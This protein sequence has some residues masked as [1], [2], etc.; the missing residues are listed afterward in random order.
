MVKFTDS[1]AIKAPVDEVFSLLADFKRYPKFIKEMKAVEVLEDKGS[2]MRV[3][4]CVNMVKDVTYT[5]DMHLKE[6][7]TI[8]WVQTEADMIKSQQGG[9]TL[10]PLEKHLTD[11]RFTVDVEFPFWVPVSI[12]EA[13]IKAAMPNMMKAVKKEAEQ[14]TSVKGAPAKRLATK[15][16]TAGKKVAAAKKKR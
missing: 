11:A 16:A 10:T 3:R 8:S 15:K 1:I 5:L 14:G 12:A 6:P 13:G 9:W 4:F 2:R 7:T